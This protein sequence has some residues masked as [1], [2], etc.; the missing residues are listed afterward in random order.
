MNGSSDVAPPDDGE[1]TTQAWSDRSSGASPAGPPAA[2]YGTTRRLTA[3]LLL[4]AKAAP[5]VLAGCA[6]L[7]L[8]AGIVPVAAA[9]LT[10][11][12]LDRLVNDT[13]LSMVIA[14]GAGLAAVG[15]VAG[16]VP[17]LAQ[18][19]RGE[20]ERSVGL[21]AQ[22]RLYTAVDRFV[23]LPRFEDPHFLDRMRLAQ[24]AGEM[25]PNQTVEGLLGVVRS[26]ITL[27]GFLG[28]LLL[29][30]PIMAGL[31]LV[32]GIP[33]LAGEIT[34]SRRRARMFWDIGPAERRELFYAQLLSSVEAAK[35][36]R[37]FGIGPFLRGR[38]LA[39]RRTTNSAK[40][41][42]DRHEVVVQAGLSL[43]ATVVSGAGLLW[44]VR[45]AQEGGLTVGDIAIF[46]A[47]VAG[48]QAALTSI[49]GDVARS[50]QALLLFDHYLTVT[51]TG[52][53]LPGADVPQH[54][55][56]LRRGVEL[57]DVWFRYSD[58][59]PWV[60]RGVDLYIPHGQALGLVGL[61]GAGK[62]TLVK[63]LCRF[64]DPT[65]GSITWDGVDIR[66]VDVADLRRRISAVFQDY[67]HYDM[68]AAEN[69]GVG[70]LESLDDL[71]R[72]E[73]AARHAGIHDTLT[74]LPHGYRTLLSR[75][76][77]MESEKGN[78]ETGVVLSGGQW[79]RLALA[80]AFLRDRRDLMILDEPSAG[81]DA[82]AEYQIYSS[83][84]KYRDG[85]T[86]LLISHRLSAVRDA[87]HIVVLSDGQVA[88]QGDHLTLMTAR[89]L[90][91]RLFNMQ[92]AGYQNEPPE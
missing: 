29:L 89:G 16:T 62:S 30:S 56:V 12:V 19:L 49:A 51:T 1:G 10:K 67:M 4:A 92:A 38:M 74:A 33:T 50:H 65:R 31:V 3:A 48:V 80:R 34:L 24:R 20:L 68:T 36:V 60:L 66:T 14:L 26:A 73:K 71:A 84:R 2:A 15:I 17:H 21:L 11:L 87:E 83:L 37:L 82:E 41:A 8:T 53:D 91:A 18:Y 64:Y 78:P 88:E 6:A 45:A 46:I 69:V 85:Q 5:G 22:D 44:A 61:N 59:H 79:Q 77:F 58:E 57:R 9:W 39:D 86:S 43:I 75:I 70:D 28:S 23:G 81:L 32:G 72:I 25:A 55:P 42:V 63:L 52:P 90:Y 13:E 7:T 40:R 35:E 27:S 76:F 47:A 54:L